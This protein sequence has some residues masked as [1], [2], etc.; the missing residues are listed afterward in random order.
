MAIMHIADLIKEA[1][2]NIE[3]L[4]NETYTQVHASDVGLDQRCGFMYISEDSVVVSDATSR[5]LNYY[6]GFEYISSEFVD[7][8]GNWVIYQS[9]T[10]RVDEVIDRFFKREPRE[11]YG[12]NE[13]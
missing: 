9:G 13:Y 6:G 10:G 7:R 2:Y 1:N 11:D 8:I 5:S 12:D 3:R 4:I